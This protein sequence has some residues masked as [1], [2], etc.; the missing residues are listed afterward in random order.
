MGEKKRCAWKT[1]ASSFWVVDPKRKTVK[2]PRRIARRSRT[3]KATNSAERSFRGRARRFGNIL[4]GLNLYGL[5]R[6][7]EPRIGDGD[8]DSGAGVLIIHTI[9]KHRERMAIIEQGFT[10][11][12]KDSKKTDS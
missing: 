4:K 9:L 5:D 7:L 12:V 1:A 3:S 8:S 11:S 2:S 6:L 10:R